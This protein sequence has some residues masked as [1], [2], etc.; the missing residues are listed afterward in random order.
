MPACTVVLENGLILEA[1]CIACLRF[2][3]VDLEEVILQGKG[4][5][6][7]IGKKPTCQ[8]CGQK[9]EW[10]IRPKGTAVGTG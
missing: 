10:Q 4:D 6:S 8:K 5:R 7:C 2:V 3:P 9:G 1:H